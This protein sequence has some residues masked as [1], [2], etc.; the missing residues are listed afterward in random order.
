MGTFKVLE[1]LDKDRSRVFAETQIVI[2]KT[3]RNFLGIENGD[4]I[5]WSK[6]EMQK[7]GMVTITIRIFKAKKVGKEKEKEKR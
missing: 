7:A 6:L 2:P 1:L 5:E 4:E 3:V